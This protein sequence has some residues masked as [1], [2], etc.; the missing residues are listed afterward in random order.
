MLETTSKPIQKSVYLDE[1]TLDL[2]DKTSADLSISRSAMIRILI[3]RY[4]TEKKSS[5]NDIEKHIDLL[6]NGRNP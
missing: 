3:N 1:K 4:C 6:S 2:L 5:F